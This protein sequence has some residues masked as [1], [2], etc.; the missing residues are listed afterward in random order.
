[1]NNRASIPDRKS[2]PS[3]APG[4]RSLSLKYSRVI[5]TLATD[6]DTEVALAAA[7]RRRRVRPVEVLRQLLVVRAS[8]AAAVAAVAARQHLCLNKG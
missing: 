5:G 4:T 3:L 7:C 6:L 1:M 2:H 8:G